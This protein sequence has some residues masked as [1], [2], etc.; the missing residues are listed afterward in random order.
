MPL[1]ITDRYI[2]QEF[3]KV[4][5]VCLMGFVLVFLLLE[6]TD[7][8]S[9]Y[10]KYNAPAWLMI[11]YFLVRLP[12]YLFFA[13]PLSILLGGMLSLLMMARHSEII[14]M[15]ANGIDALS[16]ARPVI[17]VGCVATVLMFFAD[18]TIIPWSNSYSEY[19][20]R[21]QIE[22]KKD[23]TLFKSDQIWLRTPEAITHIRKF[24]RA[25]KTLERVSIISWDADYMLKERIFADK[26]RW[27]TDRWIFYGVNRTVRTADGRFQVD[28]LP[29]MDGPLES[30]PDDLDSLEKVAKEMNLTQLSSYINGLANEGP[31][32]ARYLV[33]WHDKIAF[34][35][36]CL[37]MAALGVPF[38]IRVHPRGGGVA[39][40][41]AI[42]IVVAFG[43]WIVHTMFLALG[44]GGYIPPFA[45]AWATNVIFG[46][47]ATILVL[48]AGT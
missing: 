36:V 30:S 39:L 7:K 20:L 15:Q 12:G 19:I 47:T 42:S 40:G 17:W 38:A 8:I 37:I 10:S 6:I 21:V 5:A 46:L 24:D 25:Q 29:S 14:A 48:Q 3:L 41:L 1:R 9:H 4:F 16:V 18:E 22:R 27:W 28:V 44:H 33:D 31:V 11:K 34:P 43:F 32:P 13:V 45:A 26:A 23:T 35:F 2:I